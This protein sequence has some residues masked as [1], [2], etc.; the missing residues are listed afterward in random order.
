MNALNIHVPAANRSHPQ[1][2]RLAYQTDGAG[3]L[4]ASYTY[5]QAG[6]PESVQVGAD[7]TTAPRSYDVYDARGDVVNLTDASG[8]VVASYAYDSWGNLTSASEAIPNANGW[9]N[10]YRYDGRDGVRYDAATNFDWLSVRAY[11]PT[12]PRQQ[13][14]QFLWRGDGTLADEALADI[15]GGRAR[16]QA[17]LLQQG[18]RWLWGRRA[19]GQRHARLIVVGH[20]HAQG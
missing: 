6:A 13:R 1:F 16:E 18:N 14:A 3:T 10:P 19:P 7:P 12:L 20:L 4:L 8:A 15:G 11:D 17:A 2:G 9:V 5:D